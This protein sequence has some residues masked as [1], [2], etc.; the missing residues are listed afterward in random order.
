MSVRFTGKT[1]RALVVLTAVVGL[2]LGATACGGGGGGDDKKPERSSSASRTSGSQPGPQEGTSEEPLA[3]MKGPNGLLLQITSAQRDSGGFVTVNGVLKND[4][5]QVAVIP[6]ELSGNETEIMN[7]GRS[8]AEPP[9]STRRARSA[10][11]SCGTRRAYR[12]P[13]RGSRR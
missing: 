13:R 7:N 5:G 2:G 9:S 10:T 8:S 1:R 3:E 6:L 12:S 4:S 11:T